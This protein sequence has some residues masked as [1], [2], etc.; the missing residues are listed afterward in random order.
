MLTWLEASVVN[1]T[2]AIETVNKL[3]CNTVNAIGVGRKAGQLMKTW[4][5]LARCVCVCDEATATA[6][7][8]PNGY[9]DD[10]RR[11]LP[12]SPPPVRI[13]YLRVLLFECLRPYKQHTSNYYNVMFDNSR[14]PA[15]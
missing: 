7:L 10:E 4:P 2:N 6:A 13:L 3:F 5:L 8:K 15:P 9:C 1:H 11:R 14:P 12:P